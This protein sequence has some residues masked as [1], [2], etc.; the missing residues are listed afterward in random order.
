MTST[1]WFQ[2]Y[3]T[4]IHTSECSKV[5]YI[6]GVKLRVPFPSFKAHIHNGTKI[7]IGMENF[8]SHKIWC[9]FFVILF[10]PWEK[11]SSEAHTL[12]NN[13]IILP[14]MAGILFSLFKALIVFYFISFFDGLKMKKKKHTWPLSSNSL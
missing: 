12:F 5:N 13:C 7:H 3:K 2:I 4:Y 6:F 10:L 9:L 11:G 8:I 14:L 1:L